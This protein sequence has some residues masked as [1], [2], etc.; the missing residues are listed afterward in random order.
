MKKEILK[1]MNEIQNELVD[2]RRELHR[3]PELS[4]Q[5]YLTCNTIKKYLKS[6]DGIEVIDFGGQTRISWYFTRR[7]KRKR[8]MCNVKG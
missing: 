3:T 6:I 1:Y 8:Q 5:E 4:M 7:K 2:I